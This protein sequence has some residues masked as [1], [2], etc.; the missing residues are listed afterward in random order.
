MREWLSPYNS[1]NS[2]KG[3]LYKNE[4]E[5]IISGKL[6]PPVEVNID[7]I[8]N[9]NLYCIW[10]NSKKIVNRNDRIMM[11]KEHLLELVE[12]CADWGVKAI[13]FAGGGEPTLHPDLSLA[14]ERCYELGLESAIITNGLFMNKDQLEKVA[15]HSR[16]IGVSV[17]SD[18][19]EV[20]K[21]CKGMDKF[22][23]VINN[24]KRLTELGAREVTFKYLIHPDNQNGIY[25]ACKL[26]KKIGVDCFH[27]RLISARY[28]NEKDKFDYGEIN[29]QLDLCHKLDSN[30]F[31]VFTIRH[32]QEGEGN[33]RIRFNKCRASPLLCMFEAD[34]TTGICIDRKGETETILCRHDNVETVRET[35]GSSSH[36]KL[37]SD[38]NPEKD[39]PKCTM[40]I[41]HE[42]IDAF[43]QDL[44][45]MNFP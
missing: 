20:Y 36:K 11:T 4:F 33:R 1:F 26:A 25:N 45:C 10:C 37:L 16:W 19:P 27:T 34:G 7:P 44:F 9:C 22:T 30:D 28:L 18:C 24:M 14:F 42:L 2:F 5:G 12:F 40:N 41:Y 23:E 8:N 3:L 13:C 21:K 31:K 6:L 29:K 38:I 32:K 43:E 39:C 15:E 35:W 17:D